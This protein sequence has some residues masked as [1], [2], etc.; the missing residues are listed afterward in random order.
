MASQ[1]GSLH[2]Y[3]ARDCQCQG[4]RQSSQKGQICSHLSLGYLP[5]AHPGA[6]T[7]VHWGMADM[8]GFLSTMLPFHRASV[9]ISHSAGL[10]VPS[11]AGNCRFCHPEVEELGGRRE[12]AELGWRSWGGTARLGNQERCGGIISVPGRRMVP[13]SCVPGSNHF[14]IPSSPSLLIRHLAQANHVGKPR[15]F[16]W[17]SCALAVPTTSSGPC[18]DSAHFRAGRCLTAVTRLFFW[19]ILLTLYHA[20]CKNGLDAIPI[21]SWITSWG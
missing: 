9:C 5:G 15:P 16:C 7:W 6:E 14:A 4:K 20:R 3:C 19:R 17:V 21:Q 11:S 12:A 1:H 2:L 18:Q 8:R 13:V 10:G